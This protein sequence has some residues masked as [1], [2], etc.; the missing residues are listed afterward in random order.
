MANKKVRAVSEEAIQKGEQRYD[1]G[2]YTIL[3]I[4]NTT[5]RQLAMEGKIPS[6]D[7]GDLANKKPDGLVVQSS[8][9]KAVIE[10][11]PSLTSEP[12]IQR[13]INQEIEVA[14]KLC[15]LLI[16]TDGSNTFWVNSLNREF[17]TDESAT[18]LTLPFDMSQFS[19]GTIK[20]EHKALLEET[21][22]KVDL[23]ISPLISQLTPPRVIDPYPLARRVWQEIWVN[24]GK[25]PEKCLYNVVEMFVFR[26]LSDLEVLTGD[27][28][29]NKVYEKAI[30]E[31]DGDALT[32][33]AQIVRPKIRSLF[34]ASTTDNTTIING[35]IFVN[36]KGE[37]NLSQSSLFK[38][39]LKHFNSFCNEN[40]SFKHIDRNFKT[41]L[42]ESFLRQSAGVK[43]LGQYFTPRKVVQAMVRM[44]GADNLHP[45][46]RIC[47]PFCGVGGFLLELINLTGSIEEQFYPCDGEVNPSITLIGYDKGTDEKE[48]ERTIILAKANML[49]YFSQIIELFH[50]PEHVVEYAKAINKTFHLLRDNLGTYALEL[51]D[52]KKFDLILTNPPYVTSGSTS[53]KEELARKHLSKKYTAGGTGKEGIALE[54]IIRN[55][56]DNG[57]ALIVVPDGIL[58]RSSDESLRNFI[59]ENCIIQGIISLP[60][61]TFFATPKQTYILILTKKTN[62]YQQ[63]SPVFTYLVSEIGETRDANRFEDGVE[64][65][66]IEATNLF[67]QFKGAPG[68]F[69]SHSL[70]CK[71]QPFDRF[72]ADH[73]WLVDR[74]WSL[75][76]KKAL[77]IEDEVSQISETGFI[78]ILT[79]IEN[80]FSE[81]KEVVKDLKRAGEDVSFDKIRFSE[82]SL[83]DESI[84]ALSIGD[85]VVQKDLRGI[86]GTIPVFSANVFNPFGYLPKSNITDFT[87]DSILWGIDGNFDLNIIPRG[88][89][90]A[91]TDHCGRIQSLRDDISPRY[92]MYSLMQLRSELA[93]GRTYRASLTN[94]RKVSILIPMLND[95]SFDIKTQE[96]LAHRFCCIEAIKQEAIDK[97][98]RMSNLSVV[99]DEE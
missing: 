64:N 92:I 24:T 7:Y 55:L 82:V 80:S 79:D 60:V 33:Y 71:I 15:K 29:F 2:R 50:T 1:F 73:H 38:N 13:A 69:V 41:K 61:R 36:E 53:I 75:E 78:D 85:R 77:G 23:T 12:E 99:F 74:W 44:S 48:D 43:A 8:T 14:R 91:T 84:F 67:N 31:S 87:R 30:K 98:K 86:E 26:F 68:S 57:R 76:E 96:I 62:K 22:Y 54:W 5:L 20:E 59:K 40:G 25:N 6:V 58:S 72:N 88:Q 66:L 21:I 37:A 45:R 4:G 81:M 39:T 89:E 9:V 93:F 47:D 94:I 46:A 95:G 10:Y 51:D 18:R 49:I 27:Y 83:S 35:T 65:H 97:I 52:D 32:Y 17:I 28:S 90:F 34:P 42:Y 11:K 19:D 3:S 16:V 56:K 63:T 70:R